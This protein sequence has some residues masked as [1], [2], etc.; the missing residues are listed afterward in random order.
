[1]PEIRVII[2]RYHRA[3][4]VTRA[5]DRVPAPSGAVAEIRSSIGLVPLG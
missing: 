1:M 3:R 5:L 4:G 2:P